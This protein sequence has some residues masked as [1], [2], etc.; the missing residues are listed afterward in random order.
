MKKILMVLSV[1]SLN[2]YA[3]DDSIAVLEKFRLPDEPF[4]I[5]QTINRDIKVGQ[6]TDLVNYLLDNLNDE[7]QQLIS[8]DYH[9]LNREKSKKYEQEDSELIAKLQ[10]YY[11]LNA[12]GIIDI[13][14]WNVLLKKAN[15]WKAKMINDS[16]EELYKVKLKQAQHNSS[17][18]IIVNIPNMMAYAYNYDV[19]SQ[20]SNLSVAT[21]VVI[22]KTNTK[23][24]LQDFEIWGVKYNPDW[25]PTANMINRSVIRNGSV[26]TA[27]L[28]SHNI[29]VTN[30]AGERVNY[31]EIE[32]SGKY[33]YRQ[34]SGNSN[35]LGVFKFETTSRENIYLHDTNEKNL[36]KNNLRSYSS[37]CIRVQDYMDLAQ[38]VLDKDQDTIQAQ[39]DKEKL[40]IERV[41][42]NVPVYFTYAI[43]M[44]VSQG[45]PAYY[46]DIY[47][48]SLKLV[49]HR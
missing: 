37:G 42:E 29:T 10:D 46:T 45:Y 19:A 35:A 13:Q 44:P 43:A 14:T 38:F 49:N 34:P 36:F 2:A 12:T 39:I 33:R 27:W 26:N 4:V 24:P 47:S 25:T 28:K 17:K 11:S 40:K 18:Y 16:L 6:K 5:A 48:K 21:K 20:V 3:V 15:G 8:E 1:F 41:N 32:P 31:A 23:T 9:Y 22:G 30:H 7:A